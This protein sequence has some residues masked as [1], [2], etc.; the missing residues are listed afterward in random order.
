MPPYPI[1]LLNDLHEHF[2]DI[3]Y[4]PERFQNVQDLLLYIRQVASINPYMSGRNLYRT[5]TQRPTVSF[6]NISSLINS[7]INEMMSDDNAIDNTPTVGSTYSAN[8]NQ[9]YIDLEQ[10]FRFVIA[11]AVAN[12]VANHEEF[13]Q[14]VPIQPTVEQIAESTSVYTSNRTLDDICT[15]CQENI[16]SAQQVRSITECGHYFHKS[17]IDV[18][19]T[20]NTLCPT[21]RYDIRG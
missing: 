21:C 4:N 11:N 6:N 10:Q 18:W 1:Q 12:T 17:C 9:D 2:P 3:L 20:N 13:L 16:E 8:M 19:F 7:V 15:I 5:Y 14:P